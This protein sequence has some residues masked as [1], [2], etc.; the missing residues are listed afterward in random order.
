M[1]QEIAH[2]LLTNALHKVVALLDN[3]RQFYNLYI[4]FASLSQLSWIF[5]LPATHGH[6]PPSAPLLAG[7]WSW[8]IEMSL[9]LCSTAQQQLKH[10]YVINIAFLLKLK[11]SIM[12]DT[13]KKIPAEIWAAWPCGWQ[14]YGWGL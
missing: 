2:C 1:H 3:S 8:E 13:M 12:A 7:E 14:A 10:Q 4:P 11:Y 9:S 5:P 6:V